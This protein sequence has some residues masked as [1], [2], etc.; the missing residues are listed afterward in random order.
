MGFKKSKQE[1]ARY[2]HAKKVQRAAQDID[3][4]NAEKDKF[5]KQSQ[6]YCK[7]LDDILQAL[8]SVDLQVS[9]IKPLLHLDSLQERCESLLEHVTI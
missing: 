4:S 9:E 1:A 8:H 3:A 7:K 6:V 2:A 5:E